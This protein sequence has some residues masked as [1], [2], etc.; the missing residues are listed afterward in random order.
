M[1]KWFAHEKISSRQPTNKK[2]FTP[3]RC[4]KRR[5]TNPTPV[6][7]PPLCLQSVVSS[8]PFYSLSFLYSPFPPPFNRPSFEDETFPPADGGL[9]MFTSLR[10]LNRWQTT[11]HLSKRPPSPNTSC[12]IFTKMALISHI[13]Q[14]ILLDDPVKLSEWLSRNSEEVNTQND[15][16]WIDETPLSWAIKNM[17]HT[18]KSVLPRGADPEH[19]DENGYTMW[20]KCIMQDDISAVQLLLTHGQPSRRGISPEITEH[21]LLLDNVR[22]LKLCIF[23]NIEIRSERRY[24]ILLTTL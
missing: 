20:E 16:F 21:I 3:R 10:N 2:K 23:N 22:I 5:P 24:P 4:S 6:K 1:A 18:V 8:S 11:S 9:M 17:C 15:F 12:R 7:A 13:F 19:T 14:L